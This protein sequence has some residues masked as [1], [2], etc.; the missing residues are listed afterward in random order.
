MI[1]TNTEHLTYRLLFCYTYY[2]MREQ[3]RTQQDYAKTRRWIP[4]QKCNKN[5]ADVFALA[6]DA[7]I[8]PV[9]AQILINRGVD[10][11]AEALRFLNPSLDDL[12]D[13]FLL[14]DMGPAVA[15]IKRALAN[16]EKILIHGDYDCDGLTSTALIVRTLRALGGHVEYFVPERHKD[17]YGI[18]PCTADDAKKRGISLIITADC[19]IT[20]CDTAAKAKDLDVDLI[21][22]DHHIPGPDTPQCIAVVNPKREGSKY[23]FTELAGVGVA[24]KLCEALVRELGYN[25]RNYQ[26]KFLD[27]VALGTVA[28]VA[29]ILG[30]NR[31]M[32]KHGLNTFPKTKKTGLRALLESS[33]L[34]ERSD[35]LTSYHLGFILGPRMN[36]MGRMDNA[37]MAL[38]LLLTKDDAEAADICRELEKMNSQRQIE[39]KIIFEKAC[40]MIEERDIGQLRAL[41]LAAPDWKPGLV[42]IAAN[43]I[44]ETYNLPTILLTADEESGIGTGSAR[45]I[46]GFNILEALSECEDLLERYGGHSQAA[47]VTV[48]LENIDELE[49]RLSIA[50]EQ[51]LPE[52]AFIPHIDIDAF[53]DPGDISVRLAEEIAMLEPFGEGNPEPVFVSR[54]MTILDKRPVGQN[55]EHL[56]M[57]V[58]GECCEPV[59]C[60]AFGYGEVEKDLI[61]GSD[62]DICYNLRIN[63]FNGRR[64]AQIFIIDFD[65][66]D[67][68]AADSTDIWN[69]A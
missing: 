42:G 1:L 17:G 69:D 10:S 47:G 57:S 33:K 68:H 66:S 32:V 14:P 16:K 35:S 41:V 5:G 56:K 13:P 22:T 27:L 53:L 38:A 12:Y 15:R 60:I 34:L 18:K 51:H 43:R 25:V 39:Q 20:A 40:K 6:R 8:S 63:E 30:E 19:G 54:G 46:E 23:P 2:I 11:T 26:Q 55:G 44:V 61:A 37:A 24:F 9:T 64:T 52:E 48:R 50:A 31:I 58:R 67:A 28:D 7:E 36:A 4:A 62:I 65:N 29:P 21:I 3:N 45:S 49:R 59:D